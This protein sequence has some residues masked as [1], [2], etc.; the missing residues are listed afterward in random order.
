LELDVLVV[1]IEE[2]PGGDADQR[3]PIARIEIANRSGLAPVSDYEVVLRPTVGEA[4]QPATVYGHVRDDGWLKLV[5]AALRA[6][7]PDGGFYGSPVTQVPPA[8]LD[9]L[10]LAPYTSRACQTGRAILAAGPELDAVLNANGL[11]REAWAQEFF[12]SCRAT[13]KWTG[14]QCQDPSHGDRCSTC[15]TLVEPYG[16]VRHH[17]AVHAAA[18]QL[19]EDGPASPASPAVDGEP[20][21]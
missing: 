16:M 12:A 14:L 9:L 4:S 5:R 21:C 8:V 6:V 1:R 17:R 15:G 20:S 10:P 11:E 7:D 18:E 19:A 13:E 2:W 3:R